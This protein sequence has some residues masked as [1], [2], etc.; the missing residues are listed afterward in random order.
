MS[1]HPSESQFN[2]FVV[3]KNSLINI[4]LYINKK[5]E[6]VWNIYFSSLLSL[7]NWKT[8]PVGITL[9]VFWNTCQIGQCK[10]KHDNYF[11]KYTESFSVTED[12]RWHKM[13]LHCAV[14]ARC[15]STVLDHVWIYR[16]FIFSSKTTIYFKMILCQS[17]AAQT[18]WNYYNARIEKQRQIFKAR[19][20]DSCSFSLR[21]LKSR[22][23]A[24]Y[25]PEG[26]YGDL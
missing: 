12:K 20:T 19:H 7:L 3:T 4:N 25:K 26:A 24:L 9:E 13:Y 18:H 14:W 11:A 23:I 15:F 10:H 22:V 21:C 17:T 8:Y 2:I 6:L 16:T 5:T 1:Q